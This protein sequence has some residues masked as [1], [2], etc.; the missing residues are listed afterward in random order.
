MIQAPNVDERTAR[1]ISADVRELLSSVRW[2]ED[3]Q[4]GAFD[5]ALIH[6]FAR[7]SELIIH[8]LNQAPEKNFL[9]F[10]DLLGVSQLPMQA[11]R[12]PITFSIAAGSTSCVRV[13]AGTQ[14]AAAPSEG[15]KKPVIFETERE[16][17]VTPARLDSLLV[18][19][20][21]CD[22][23]KDL[24][25]VLLLPSGPDGTSNAV[26]LSSANALL[27][28]HVLYI[29]LPVS[30]SW[31]KIDRLRVRFAFEGGG[32]QVEGRVLQWEMPTA[33]DPPRVFAGAAKLSGGAI[34]ALQVGANVVLI[35]Q[36]DSTGNLAQSGDIVF[37][38]P[39]VGAPVAL[40]GIS[41]YWV[42]CRLMTPIT[43]SEEP[44]AGM[45]RASQLPTVK[46]ITCQMEL[47]RQGLGLE[48]AF[49]NAQKLDLS[50]DF[51]P[52]GERPKFGDV[53]YL[54]SR[55]VFSDPDAQ[56]TLHVEMT[57]PAVAEA[58]AAILANPKPQLSWEFW[59]GQEWATLGR[60]GRLSRVGDSGSN[61][62][63]TEFADGTQSLT[64]DGDVK[65]RFNSPP[66][67]LNVNGQKG[68]WVRVRIASGNYGEEVHFQSDPAAPSGLVAKPSTLAP[69]SLKSIK[70]DYVVKKE[71]PPTAVLTYN[72]FAY[73]RADSQTSL[74]PF[75]PLA[76]ED[77]STS[78][79]FGFA[80]DRPPGAKPPNTSG[81]SS[82]VAK[83]QAKF[84]SQAVTVYVV[85][86]NSASEKSGDVQASAAVAAWD[87]WNGFAWKKLS[88]R[89]ETQSFRRSGLIQ[90][91]APLDFV[92][93][94]EFGRE[95]YWLRM[96]PSAAD[97]AATIRQILLN[98]TIAVQGMSVSNDVLGT[99]N[100][101]PGQKF[102]TIQ[103][104][105]LAGQKLE[106]REPTLPPHHER[107]TVK[108][109]E[110]E[111]AIQT[112][113]DPKSNS[114]H[115]WVTWHEV[116]NFYQ[117]EARDRHYVL[118][119]LK[120]EVTFGDGTRG[121]IP[122]VLPGNIR[123]TR[124]RSGGGVSGNKPA[125]AVTK[126]SSAV[127]YIQ[128]VVNYLPAEGGSD[129]EANPTLVERG[130]RQL[131]HRGRAV[132]FED[133]EDLAMLASRN[134]A[135]AKCVPLYD[136]SLD[137][138][139][140]R[141][142]PG[143]VS[144]IVVPRSSDP[145]PLPTQELLDEVSGYVDAWRLPTVEMVALGPEYIRVDVDV[146]VAVDDP[147]KA[148][149]VELAVRRE[150]ERY[151]HPISGGP[152]GAGWEFGRL[153]RKFDLSSLIEKIPGVSHVREFRVVTSGRA[154][155]EKTGYFLICCG[156][157]KVALTLEDQLA[158]ELA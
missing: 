65:F 144:L 157:F 120:G 19:F 48:Q 54:G 158:V 112:V 79:H 74:A 22:R 150:L 104:M 61:D 28:P 75:I 73:A 85:A 89:D 130:S 124:Y 139:K 38:N 68:Y 103:P 71:A 142:T 119:R 37:A 6:V 62:A 34:P 41:G 4:K 105:V 26:T 146:E 100:G 137:V 145:E 63:A 3:E 12:V 152:D 94:R 153:P 16:L 101:K 29:A 40:N 67:E 77:A 15:E 18:K 23:Y 92:I 43:R 69:P 52:F 132:T 135:R 122:P 35:P 87:Y 72:D 30:A 8:R 154:G 82:E 21:S 58:D 111:D 133:F 90:F 151:L 98:T 86:G 80:V 143:L 60:S 118:D 56:I 45:V 148:N 50:K 5:S 117:S 128:K 83:R 13:P 66:Q 127:P 156:E 126:L 49:Y 114:D 129:A 10:L 110:G 107:Q 149:E 96:R 17:V 2:P 24:G 47:A 14:I 97:C 108:S 115:F 55:E 134:V 33:D 106:V 51:F 76:P 88:L 36:E 20:G 131:R 123:M 11:A 42:G 99:S 141:R 116:P 81:A 57:K 1:E 32:N 113:K 91:I 136:L 147:G 78:L 59:N 9:A 25:P 31:P 53:L 140:R 125:Q 95:R 39:P 138:E 7:F 46:Q 84:P 155:V 44:V 93:K 70:I 64:S 109:D 121:L 27:I 102:Q